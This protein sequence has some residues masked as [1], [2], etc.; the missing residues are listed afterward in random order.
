MAG[1]T[2]WIGGGAIGILLTVVPF[3]FFR[4]EYTHAK[5]LR[6]VVP[7]RVYRSG[8]LTES[9]FAEAVQRYHLRTVINLQDEF[10]DPDI[11]RGYFTARTIKEKQ[12]CDRLGV[13]YIFIAPDLVPRRQAPAERPEAIDQFLAVMDDPQAYPVLIHCKAGL[14]RTG[15]MVAVYRME[16]QGWTPLEAVREMKANGFGEWVCSSAN[17][18]ITQYVLTFRPGRRGALSRTLPPMFGRLA[19]GER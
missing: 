6:E 3:L 13:R 15:V 14:H 16:Y 12:L 11:A 9:G 18:Y 5:R 19:V 10:P 4:W 2:R 7:E 1:V 17:D 8:Q